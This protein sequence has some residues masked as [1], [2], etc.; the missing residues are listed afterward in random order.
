[1][2]DWNQV[3]KQVEK[4]AGKPVKDMKIPGAVTKASASYE[5]AADD[6]DKARD[7]LEEK[8]LAF[9]NAVSGHYNAVKMFADKMQ[10]L[11]FGMDT[12]AADYKSKRAEIQKL[13]DSVLD[14]SMKASQGN[15]KNTDELEKHMRNLA[16]YK[17]PEA[18]EL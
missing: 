5:K 4:I 17:S 15:I 1:M 11:D 6:F 7:V 12:K 2:A 8:I 16:S 9:Q 10:G 3:V 13:I 14:P 18:P